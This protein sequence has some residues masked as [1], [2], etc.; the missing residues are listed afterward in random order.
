MRRLL[1]VGLK[2]VVALVVVV[3]AATAFLGYRLA[4][5]ALP[6]LVASACLLLDGL[7]H[8]AKA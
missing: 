1:R 3:A 7:T 8:R 2:L 6:L 5:F 4:F